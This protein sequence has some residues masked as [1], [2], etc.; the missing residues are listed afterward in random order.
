MYGTDPTL[1]HDTLFY[2]AKYGMDVNKCINIELKRQYG[3]MGYSSIEFCNSN[4]DVEPYDFLDYLFMVLLFGLVAIVGSATYLDKRLNP[5]TT[6]EHYKNDVTEAK[7]GTRV[8][9]SFSLPR[10]WYR[11]VTPSNTVMGKDLRY[12]QGLRVVSVFGVV[13]SHVF[14]GFNFAPAINPEYIEGKF[15]TFGITSELT[16]L[17]L[18]R[19]V[20]QCL[21]HDDVEWNDGCPNL[22]HHQWFSAHSPVCRDDPTIQTERLELQLLLDRYDLSVY[23]THTSL[24]PN[25]SL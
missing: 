24:R 2:R 21:V 12:V 22:L 23:P 3:L 11:L 19:F 7:L 18:P 4:Q 20:S 13:Y 16:D 17:L 9:L 14:L 25:H 15:F 1:I 5:T 10:N 8:L 6:M